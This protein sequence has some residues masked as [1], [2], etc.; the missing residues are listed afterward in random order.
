[1]PDIDANILNRIFRQ[2]QRDTVKKNEAFKQAEDY[3]NCIKCDIKDFSPLTYYYI[4]CKLDDFKKIDFIKENSDYIKINAKEIFKE[5]GLDNYSISSYF[6]FNVLK[7]INDFD[8]ELFRIILKY[9]K[10]D[11]F[12]NFENA[13][14][15]NFF[16]ECYSN[17]NSLD[18]DIFI[19]K[20]E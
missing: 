5:H 9:S 16:K 11:F 13:D 14:Y 8:S 3:I 20:I 15:Y 6:T 17:I 10:E 18:N 4:I 19:S 7:K 12:N 2:L 1:M